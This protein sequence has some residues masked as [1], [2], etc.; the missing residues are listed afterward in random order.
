VTEKKANF[1]AFMWDLKLGVMYEFRAKRGGED[2]ESRL[3]GEYRQVF[4]RK[5]IPSY[6]ESAS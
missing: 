5:E 1:F 4:D 2:N 6:S 3:G